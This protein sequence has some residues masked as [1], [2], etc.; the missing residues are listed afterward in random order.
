MRWLIACS[1]DKKGKNPISKQWEMYRLSMVTL[2]FKENMQDDRLARKLLSMWLEMAKYRWNLEH[3]VWKAEPQERGAIHF[4]IVTGLYL[5]HKEV[6]Y[7]WN[8]LLLKH[9][10]D[11]RN[12]NSTDAHGVFRVNN[13]EAYLTEYLMNEDKHAGRRPITGKLWGCSH[14]LAQAG[15]LYLYIDNDDAQAI[16]FDNSLLS[17]QNKYDKAPKFLEFTDIYLLPSDY[18]SKLPACEI[19]DLYNAEL[20]LLE[21]EL[22]TKAFW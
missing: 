19:K 11:Q 20:K 8:R 17:L 7:T 9:G 13:L 18:Y 3:Y 10:L 2:T 14:K 22:S 5:P 6:C 1:K 12:A 16:R 15:K 21:P 4:H